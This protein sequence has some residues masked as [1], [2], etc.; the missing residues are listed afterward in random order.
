MAAHHHCQFIAL[1][2]LRRVRNLH[3][4]FTLV[5]LLVVI[6]IVGVL[7]A[8][9]L[10]SVQGAR[11]AARRTHCINNL[12]Q[13]GLALHGFH[14]ARRHFPPGTPGSDR[15][16]AGGRPF[17]HSWVTYI[18]PMLGE[19]ALY[20][21]YDFNVTWSRAP[22]NRVTVN[23]TLPVQWCPTSEHKWLDQGDYGGIFG[24]GRTSGL[25]L[26]KPAALSGFFNCVDSTRVETGTRIRDITDG[27][28]YTFA[29]IESAG[30]TAWH[31]YWGN[32]TS[33]YAPH[34][35]IND[36]RSTASTVEIFSDHASGAFGLF[37]DASVHYLHETMP[38]LLINQL[39]TRANNE[40]FDPAELERER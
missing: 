21:L 3:F 32:G 1:G 33:E 35:L 10:P 15:Q 6:A 39:C 18:L 14:D 13:H 20:D 17:H 5:E 12:K 19:Q 9:L 38:Q 7:V 26:K 4:G 31:N 24:P 27:T 23:F 22:N 40:L 29:V 28:K 16:D 36:D 25:N 8:L 11:E 37:A 30:G 34:G 2:R